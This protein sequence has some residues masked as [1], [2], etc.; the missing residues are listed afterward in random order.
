LASAYGVAGESWTL[1]TRARIPL[2]PISAEWSLPPSSTVH[3]KDPL[4]P[5][6]PQP[7]RTFITSLSVYLLIVNSGF[8]E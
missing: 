4:K 5:A 8:Q 1:V 7:T 2:L 3:D 6:P